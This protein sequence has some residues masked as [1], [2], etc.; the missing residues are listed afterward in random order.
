QT[1]DLNSWIAQWGAVPCLITGALGGGAA[2]CNV[3]GQLA[4]S[5]TDQSEIL[6]LLTSMFIHGG[7]LHILGNMIF[8]WVFGDNVEDAM[9][10]VGYLLFYLLCG[11]GAGLGQVFADPTAAV[12]AVGASG[13]IAGVLGAYLVLYPRASVRTVIPIIIIPWI[14]RIPAV[15]LMLFWF[16]TQ[17]ISSNLFSVSSAVGGSGGVAYMAHIV[18]FILGLALVFVFRGRQRSID[19]EHTW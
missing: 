8:L 1:P 9:G 3:H 13:A 5:G 17:L 12:P 14:V 15:V 7:W 10:H 2:T 18:G 16:T 11:V 4:Q 19:V 6:H